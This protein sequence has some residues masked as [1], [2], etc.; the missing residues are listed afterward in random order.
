MLCAVFAVS[1]FMTVTALTGNAEQDGVAAALTCDKTAY[2]AEEAV[3]ITLTVKNNNSY[4]VKGIETEIILPEGIKAQADALKQSAF[5]L[6]SGESKVQQLSSTVE[7]A[8]ESPKTSDSSYVG[9][10]ILLMLLSGGALVLVCVKKGLLRKKGIVPL[11]LCIAVVG[12][13]F[14]PLAVNA[15]STAKGFTVENSIKYDGKDVTVKA[16]ISYLKEIP[17]KVI[18]NGKESFYVVGEVVEITAPE[19]AEGEH[20]V[21]WEVVK[22]DVKLDNA[23]NASTSFVKPNGEIELKPIYAPNTYTI[24]VTTNDGGATSPAGEISVKHNESQIVE[25]TPNEHYHIAEVKVDGQSK[26]TIGSYEFKNVKENHTIEVTFEIDTVTI[27]IGWGILG[28]GIPANHPTAALG[29]QQVIETK[30]VAYGDDLTLV[31]EECI[32]K[33][34]AATG[35]P[36]SDFSRPPQV[37]YVYKEGT[38]YTFENVTESHI[39]VFPEEKKVA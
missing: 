4:P 27:S 12:A 2:S 8:T 19:P 20:F 23:A 11:L 22:G 9:Y 25:I 29:M 38:S 14:A 37:D 17:E 18:L 1:A 33:I 21:G 16:K 3:G 5:T 30:T 39:V 32:Q 31:F 26:G 28:E 35:K 36:R 15:E 24:T 6:N 10:F 13:A 7:K 34:C